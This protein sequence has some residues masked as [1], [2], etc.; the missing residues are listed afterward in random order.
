M[1]QAITTFFDRVVHIETLVAYL[2]T[3]DSDGILAWHGPGCCMLVNSNSSQ[4]WV[5]CWG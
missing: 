1:T 5:G 2:E 4:Q 3:C